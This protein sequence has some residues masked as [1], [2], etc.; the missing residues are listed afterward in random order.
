MHVSMR[1]T[2]LAIGLLAFASVAYGNPQVGPSAAWYGELKAECYYNEADEFVLK[3]GLDTEA[4]ICFAKTYKKGTKTIRINSEGGQGAIALALAHRLKGEKFHLIIEE[5]CHSACTLFIMPLAEEITLE[6]EAAILL[7][8]APSKTQLTKAFKA[9]IIQ[10]GIERGLSKKQALKEYKNFKKYGKRQI[11]AAKTF[12][13]EYNVGDGWFMKTGK[14]AVDEKAI[15]VEQDD[16]TW[17]QDNQV[18]GF[19]VGRSFIESCLPDVKINTFFGPS[20]PEHLTSP[21]FQ[22]RLKKA[23][24]AILPQAQC[25]E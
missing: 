16:V 2:I 11:A 1:L 4:R 22:K 9:N 15:P 5:Q 18:I 21:S 13:K 24:V 7:H 19:L 25:L 17:M 12:R 3:G 10:E 8:G 20:H 23:S 6:K 14:W